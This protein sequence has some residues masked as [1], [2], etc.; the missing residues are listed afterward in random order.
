MNLPPAMLG[1]KPFGTPLRDL[2][3]VELLFEE[4][5]A[6]R[7]ADYEDLNQE[8]AAIKMGISRPTFTR[9]YDKARKTVAKALA[10]SKVIVISGG[11][12]KFDK[13]WFK[14]LKC[15]EN[16]ISRPTEKHSCGHCDSD[17]TI[18]IG[19]NFEEETKKS[20][21][22]NKYCYCPNCEA[23]I[24]HK[25]GIPCCSLKCPYCNAVLKGN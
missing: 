22:G 13:D 14:C 2:E 20:F 1:F 11:N 12:V 9:I 19:E 18:K 4:F 7:L 6:I 16:F 17:D 8:E 21:H 15:D 23:E 24:D 5:E 10:E 25:Q 3:A